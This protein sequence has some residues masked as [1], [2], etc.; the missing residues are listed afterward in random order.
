MKRKTTHQYFVFNV[1]DG[2]KVIN[3]TLN[4]YG[5]EGWTLATMITIAGGEKI[6]A[7]MYQVEEIETPD[8]K[9]SKATKIASLWSGDE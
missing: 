7:W 6:V 1:E 3:E 9:K 2:P 8:G 5:D 4:T